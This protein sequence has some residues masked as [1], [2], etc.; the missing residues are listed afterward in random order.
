MLFK[1]PVSEL[2]TDVLQDCKSSASVGLN[3][4]F[5]LLIIVVNF[6]FY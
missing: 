4:G 1:A 6:Y 2:P 5:N 3:N